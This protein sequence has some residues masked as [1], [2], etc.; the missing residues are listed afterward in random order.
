MLEKSKAK[1]KA[2]RLRHS[3]KQ[4]FGRDGHRNGDQK[5]VYDSLVTENIYK[6]SVEEKAVAYTAR[7]F[8]VKI[9]RHLTKEDHE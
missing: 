3:M 8:A 6:T 4:V 1:K 7:D 5:R 9:H 2:D